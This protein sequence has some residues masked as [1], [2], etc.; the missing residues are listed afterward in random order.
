MAREVH[1]DIDLVRVDARGHGGEIHAMHRDEMIHGPFDQ[2]RIAVPRRAQRIGV[3]LE[4]PC[5]MRGQQ[6]IVE[7]EHHVLAEVRRKVADAQAAVR[8]L[9][10]P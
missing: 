1:E 3:E 6:L 10:W 5:R 4:R 9:P 8:L 2:L 7:S